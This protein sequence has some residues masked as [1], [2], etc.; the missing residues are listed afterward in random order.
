[1]PERERDKEIVLRCAI[2]MTRSELPFI[3]FH[4]AT[5]PLYYIARDMVF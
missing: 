5:Q 4:R 2:I 3:V 1:M